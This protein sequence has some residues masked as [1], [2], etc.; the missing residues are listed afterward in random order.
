MIENRFVSVGC[1]FVAGILTGGC[2]APVEDDTTQRALMHDLATIVLYPWQSEL[3]VEAEK[4][5]AAVTAFCVTPN[6]AQLNAAQDAW[7][8]ARLPWKRAEMVRF[9]PVEDLRLG[10]AID[11]WPA[12]TDTIEAAITSAPEP[13]TSEHIASLGTSSK[14]MPAL[15]YLIFDPIGGNAAILTAIGGTDAA[16]VKR[17]AYAQAV[18]ETFANDARAL[19]TA[20]NAEAGGFVNQVADAGTGSTTFTSGQTAVGVIVNLLNASLQGAN[21]NKITA[22]FGLN[23]GSPDPS[24]VESRFSDH[25][26]EDL[27]ENLIGVEEVYYGRHGGKTGKGLTVL[28]NARSAAVDTAV[29]QALTDAQ[30]KVAAV[31][32]PFR[33]AITGAPDSV[34]ATHAAIRA[35]RIR[36]STDVASVLGIS[37]LLNDS[38]AD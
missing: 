28:V 15:E 10:A 6:D 4:V 29:K 12:R 3:A 19:E 18:A 30:A 21:E 7:R 16:S 25:S 23:T 14:G 32:P 13:I 38:D 2:S 26:L 24:V 9:G 11:F 33:T 17:C 37:I 35:L 1:V 20:W 31:P 22:P 27:K 34:T 5:E 8:A 36:L